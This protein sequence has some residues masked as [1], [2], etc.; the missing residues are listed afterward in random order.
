MDC[1]GLSQHPIGYQT[2]LSSSSA[3]TT[4]AVQTWSSGSPQSWEPLPQKKEEEEE[5]EKTRESSR[6]L[7]LQR[8]AYPSTCL[9]EGAGGCEICR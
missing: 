3:G 4:E 9:F 1:L 2:P 7:V 8:W 5:E 6:S